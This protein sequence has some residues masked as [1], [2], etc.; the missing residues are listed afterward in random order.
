MQSHIRQEHLKSIRDKFDDLM[1]ST[2]VATQ[3]VFMDRLVKAMAVYL[4]KGGYDADEKFYDA[5]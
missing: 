2:S 5:E 3:I 4:I 1:V